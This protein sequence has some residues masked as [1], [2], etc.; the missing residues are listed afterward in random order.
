M[1]VTVSF[2]SKVSR[3]TFCKIMFILIELFAGLMP[4]IAVMDR[5]QWPVEASFFQ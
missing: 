1:D 3:L 5:M 4:I 2:K